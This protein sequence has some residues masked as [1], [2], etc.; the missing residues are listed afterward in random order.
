MTSTPTTPDGVRS[1]SRPFRVLVT[2][3]RTWSDRAA[4]WTAL[5]EVLAV[6]HQVT[7]VHGACPR[8]A[9]A[10]AHDW[11]VRRQRDHQPVDEEAHPAQWRVTD[12]TTGTSRVDRGAGIARNARMVAAGAQLCLTFIDPCSVASC[13][14]PEI[15]GSHGA[16]DCATRARDAGI[17]VQH[18]T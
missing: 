12:P 7:V 17:P 16:V 3:S 4:V 6:R 10:H 8:G 5:D 14:Q 2:G 9:D 13:Q 18:R 1:D 15:H 11:V